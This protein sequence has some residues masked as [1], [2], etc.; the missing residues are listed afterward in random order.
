MTKR[1]KFWFRAV[2]ALLAVATI[3]YFAARA[4][5]IQY[6]VGHLTPGWASVADRSSLPSPDIILFGDSRAARFNEAEALLGRRVENAGIGGDTT[7]N[8][9]ARLQKDVIERKPQTVVIFAGINDLN[10]AAMHDDGERA[11]IVA[12]AQANLSAMIAACRDAGIEV[13]VP[14]VTPPVRPDFLRAIMWGNTGA[15][16]EAL[17]QTLAAMEGDGVVYLPLEMVLIDGGE[18]GQE[19]FVDALHYSPLGYERIAAALRGVMDD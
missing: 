4:A 16:V 8:M 3:A 17:N 5:Y 12:M 10:T 6:R 1:Q 18:Y 13:I 19:N 15:D 14:S 7:P 9:L 2:L 11:G